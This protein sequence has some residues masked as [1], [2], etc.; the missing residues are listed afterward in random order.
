MPHD[1]Q[2]I[3]DLTV[4]QESFN[5]LTDSVEQQF[6]F[7]A[8]SLQDAFR[9]SPWLPE[10]IRPKTPPSPSFDEPLRHSLGYLER[11]RY[12]ISEHRA[13]TAAV[14]AFIGTGVFIVWKHR[15]ADRAKRRAKRSKNG[16]KTEVVILAG[17]PHSPLTK[18]LSLDLERRGFIV[19]I[20]TVSLFLHNLTLIISIP[21]S[22]LSA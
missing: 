10:S 9:D 14:V 17:S 15:K 16:S 2:S 20:P 5:S 6:D 8:R 1:G 18:S 4:I 12:W 19:Y 11:T 13:V 22:G 3:F 7:A 21:L